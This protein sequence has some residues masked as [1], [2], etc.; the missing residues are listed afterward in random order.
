MRQKEGFVLRTV[1]GEKVIVGEGLGAIDFGKLVSLNATAAWLW[2]K[3]GEQGDFTVE[4]L[5]DALC[6]AYEVDAETAKADVQKL[7]DQWKDLGIIE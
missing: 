5:A 2:E 7:L 1:C 6:E 4:S 3:A